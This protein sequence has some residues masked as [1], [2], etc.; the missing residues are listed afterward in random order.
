MI[1]R[2]RERQ[3]RAEL[4]GQT[5][6]ERDRPQAPFEACHPLF[7]CG[8]RGIADAAVDVTVAAQREQLCRLLGRAEDVRGRLVN[9]SGARA[10]R[11]IGRRSGVKR[12]RCKT[13]FSLVLHHRRSQTLF[14]AI[15]LLSW[16]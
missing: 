5:A 9:R 13:E 15:I 11:R 3:H 12:S 6:R 10:G 1:A 7:E 4:G 8:N 14:R 16:G 2:L